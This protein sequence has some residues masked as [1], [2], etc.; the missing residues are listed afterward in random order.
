MADSN[1]RDDLKNAAHSLIDELPDNAGWEDVM[2]RV[3]VRQAVEAGLGDAREGRVV[4]VSEVRRAFGL[5]K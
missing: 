1:T 2:Y 3:Y 4:D 5:A